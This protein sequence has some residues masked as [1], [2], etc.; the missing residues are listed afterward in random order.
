MSSLSLPIVSVS[1]G[2]ALVPETDAKE[3]N[4]GRS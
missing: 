4:E 2:M 1:V 3:N